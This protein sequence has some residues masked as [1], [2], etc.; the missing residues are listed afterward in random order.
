[1]PK[2]KKSSVPIGLLMDW[3][4]PKSMLILILIAGIVILW[5]LIAFANFG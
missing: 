2:K 5:A 4:N 3:K 1:M